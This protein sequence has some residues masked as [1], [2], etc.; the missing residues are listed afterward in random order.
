[1][2]IFVIPNVTEIIYEL[3]DTP[4]KNTRYVGM[5]NPILRFFTISESEDIVAMLYGLEIDNSYSVKIAL[6]YKKTM[7]L[8]E[9]W[10][11]GYLFK[12]VEDNFPKFMINKWLVGI[13]V[14]DCVYLFSHRG[15]MWQT[16]HVGEK[17]IKSV[18]H[19]SGFIYLTGDKV[20][21]IPFHFEI[22]LP[23][24]TSKS[25]NKKGKRKRVKEKNIH[26]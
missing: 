9:N 11:S 15:D 6:W 24:R 20:Y 19:D 5:S 4:E 23:T 1:M 2:K 8:M 26:K 13:H 14:H 3:I 12:D 25:K 16:I 18:L 10:D 17:V 22:Q 7:S 21:L